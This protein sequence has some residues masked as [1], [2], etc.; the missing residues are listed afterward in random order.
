MTSPVVTVAKPT[1][2]SLASAVHPDAVMYVVSW[3]G[4][5]VPRGAVIDGH[6][7]EYANGG[8][9][10]D[11]DGYLFARFVRLLEFGGKERNEHVLHVFVLPRNDWLRV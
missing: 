2:Q 6:T 7:V 11:T 9:V 1:D 5:K 8:F 4:S 3:I 10:R